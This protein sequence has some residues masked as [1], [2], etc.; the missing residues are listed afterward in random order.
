MSQ[1]QNLGFLCPLHHF[2]YTWHFLP[3][4]I[5]KFLFRVTNWNDRPILCSITQSQLVPYRIFYRLEFFSSRN[6][7]LPEI[8][9]TKEPF[10]LSLYTP[11]TPYTLFQ[12]R[13]FF[14][15]PKQ[16][17][18]NSSVIAVLLKERICSHGDKILLL[19]QTKFS[20]GTWCVRSKQEVKKCVSLVLSGEKK[21][22]IK[23]VHFP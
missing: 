9:R 16:N 21:K 20:E 14:S 8:N 1:Q 22:T 6:L 4:G 18:V 3:Y 7:Q 5:Q 23:C 12:I 19:K 15:V 2:E 13:L 10:Y 11:S 17:D